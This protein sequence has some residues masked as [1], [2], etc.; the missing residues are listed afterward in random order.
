MFVCVHSSVHCICSLHMLNTSIELSTIPMEIIIFSHHQQCLSSLLIVLISWLCLQHL[1]VTDTNCHP[2]YHRHHHEQAPSWSVAVSTRCFQCSRSWVY[3]YAELRPRLRGWRSASRVCSQV[4]RV[5]PGGR[6]Q[7][8]GSPRMETLSALAWYQVTYP[9]LPRAQNIKAIWPGWAET[10]KAVNQLGVLPWRWL[11]GPCMECGGYG[12][13]TF[14]QRRPSE[15]YHSRKSCT[16]S[17]IKWLLVLFSRAIGYVT[18]PLIS[19]QVLE[20][21]SK[22][23]VS[24]GFFTG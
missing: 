24:Q 13:N 3:F 4:W 12:A 6:L 11:H 1:T 5:R 16:V 19:Q 9:S 20:I 8:L 22:T 7:S 2:S 17:V 14:C 18:L 15:N 23:V 10:A 21:N